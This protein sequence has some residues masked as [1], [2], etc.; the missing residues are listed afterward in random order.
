MLPLPGSSKRRARPSYPYPPQSPSTTSLIN[1]LRTRTRLTNLAVFILCLTLIISLLFNVS[2]YLAGSERRMRSSSM[3]YGYGYDGVEDAKTHV[4]ASI[5]ATIDRDP[6]L[7]LLDHLILVPGHALWIGHDAVS[8]EDDED[9]ILEPIQKGGSVKTYIQ[10]VR[11]GVKQLKEDEKA[12]LVFSGGATRPPPSPLL[13]ESQTYLS[14]AQ[15]LSLIPSTPFPPHSTASN[16]DPL[17]LNARTTTEEYALDSYENLLFALARF[18]EFTGRWPVKITVVGYGMKRRRFE[19]LHRA[20]I[21]FPLEHFDYVGIDD[22]GDTTEHYA[23][24][25]QYGFGPFVHNPSGC[26]PPLS[27]KRLLRNPFIRYHPYHTS[28]PELS[29][30]FEWCPPT[31]SVDLPAAEQEGWDLK[32]GGAVVEGFE[33]FRGWVPWDEDLTTWDRERY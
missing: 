12:L 19:Q 26:H 11:E 9:W 22:E 20:A 1:L 23:G 33:I 28:V 4:P 25:L 15:T 18:K 32:D 17:P 13:T 7:G 29:D 16:H 8:V 30:L 10:H 27:T 6:K 24:E 3:G 31:R 14:L 21:R 5:E 2:G